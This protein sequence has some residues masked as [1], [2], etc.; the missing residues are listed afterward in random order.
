M[1]YI[2]NLY[3]SYMMMLKNILKIASLLLVLAS[4][5]AYA[6]NLSPVID[7]LGDSVIYNKNGDALIIG[8]RVKVT[9]EDSPYLYGATVRITNPDPRL[10]EVL[11]ADVTGTNLRKTYADHAL[12]IEGKATPQ[13]YTNVLRTVTYTNLSDPRRAVGSVVELDVLATDS[14]NVG[15]AKQFIA[16]GNEIPK[17][18][19]TR[20]EFI[21]PASIDD[22]GRDGFGLDDI[23]AS[24]PTYELVDIN[25]GNNSGNFESSTLRLQSIPEVM[26]KSYVYNKELLAERENVKATAENVPETVSEWLPTINADWSRGLKDV[27]QKGPGLYRKDDGLADSKEVSLSLPLFDSFASTHRLKRERFNVEAAKS[28]LDAIEQEVLLNTAIAYMNVVREKQSLDLNFELE[29]S[30]RKYYDGTKTRFDLGEVTQTDVSQAYTRLTRSISDRISADGLY[31][32]SKAVYFRIVGEAPWG[33][34]LDNEDPLA[35]RVDEEAFIREAIENNPSIHVSDF[36][37]KAADHDVTS[38]KLSAV[39]PRVSLQA[40]K[41]WDSGTGLGVGVT[42]NH[43]EQVLVNVLVPIYQAGAEYARIR[44]AKR[45]EAKLE[46]DRDETIN[47]TREGVIRAMNE[48]RTSLTTIDVLKANVKT[49]RAAL[50]G[51]EHEVKVGVRSTIDLLDAQQEVFEAE[52]L[53]LRARRDRIVNAYALLEQLGRLK[54]DKLKLAVDVHNPDAYY[55]KVK[56]QVIGY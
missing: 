30:L 51:L 12:V 11:D 2:T 17:I 32:T 46:F 7:G 3:R 43:D 10:N 50:E 38:K 29:E 24:D 47:L 5:Q 31:D 48:Y 15:S 37:V 44:K 53:L 34:Y 4:S 40:S 13:Q 25:G 22:T 55:Q 18:A 39:L 19:D 1:C 35:G 54:A 21:P 23:G 49:A 16:Y 9:D 56:Y 8:P 20:P 45:T 41:G 36:N 42:S 26:A 52:V 28:R 33:L 14:R 6:K 27:K